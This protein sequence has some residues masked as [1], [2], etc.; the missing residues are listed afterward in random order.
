MPLAPQN[1]VPYI[2]LITFSLGRTDRCGAKRGVRPENVF[3]E[4]DVALTLLQPTVSHTDTNNKELTDSGLLK[5]R[6]RHVA[7]IQALARSAAQK[8][9]NACPATD[10]GSCR[11]AVQ[12]LREAP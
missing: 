9:D 2:F 11:Y 7:G 6:T 10:S 3:K 5:E 8:G 12:F 4:N 1:R